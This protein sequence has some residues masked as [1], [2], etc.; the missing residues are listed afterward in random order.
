MNA[1]PDR[2]A[3]LEALLASSARGETRLYTSAVSKV[4]VAFGAPERER[5]ELDPNVE[6]QIDSLW[7]DPRVVTVVKYYSAIGETA[8]S[9][10]RAGIARGWILKPVDAIHLATA[11]WL[12]SEGVDIEEFHTYDRRLFK[13]ADIAGF[14]IREPHV[15]HTPGI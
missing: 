11:K 6:R 8:R 5:Q 7:A 9:M 3:V 13:Y 1:I 15:A 14:P 2:I 12:R 4:E 10:T